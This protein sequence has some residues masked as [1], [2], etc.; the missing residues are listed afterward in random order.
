MARYDVA[1]IGGG[2]GGRAAAKRAVAAGMSVALVERELVGGECPYWACMPS[3]VMLRP[4]EAV[5]DASRV[6]GVSTPAV[7][8]PAVAAWRDEVIL[9]LDDTVVIKGL[10]DRGI[11]VYKAPGRIVRPGVVAA[12]EEELEC[13]HI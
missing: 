9:H 6:P 8:W 12:G 4:G 10:R 7:D 2:P 13:E 1:V 11:D 5:S 3:K